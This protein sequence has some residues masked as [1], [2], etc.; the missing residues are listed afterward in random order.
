VPDA[1]TV[2][3]AVWTLLRPVQLLLVAVVYA[4]GAAV[5]WARVGSLPLAAHAEGFAAMLFVARGRMGWGR[6]PRSAA[7]TPGLSSTHPY[8]AVL[9]SNS[10][11]ATRT[12]DVR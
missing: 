4:S 6:R 7:R 5:T 11:E 12:A 3:W 9:S 2:A 8:W 1:G 10:S